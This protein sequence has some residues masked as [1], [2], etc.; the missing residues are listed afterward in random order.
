MEAVAITLVL[1]MFNDV[2]DPRAANAR[3]RLV[4]MLAI[5]LMAMMSGADDYPG[6]V[7]Y[8]RDNKD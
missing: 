3:H 7:E 5:A 1:S 8:G 4:D 6:I 2:P